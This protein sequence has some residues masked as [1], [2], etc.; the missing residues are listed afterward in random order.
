[1]GLSYRHIYRLGSHMWELFETRITETYEEV[2]SSVL[3]SLHKKK[4]LFK[5]CL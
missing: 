3:F 4:K 1:M 5:K 2:M